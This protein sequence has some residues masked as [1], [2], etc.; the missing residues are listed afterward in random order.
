MTATVK[1][2]H[3]VNSVMSY[4]DKLNVQLEENG[5]IAKVRLI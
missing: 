2:Y 5:K 4:K 1:G 3:R